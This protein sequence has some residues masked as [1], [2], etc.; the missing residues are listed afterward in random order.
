MNRSNSRSRGTSRRPT[1]RHLTRIGP[2]HIVHMLPDNSS[3]DR[4]SIVSPRKIRP[5]SRGTIRRAERSMSMP[6]SSQSRGP[7]PTLHRRRQSPTIPPAADPRPSAQSRSQPARLRSTSGLEDR[8]DVATTIT[9]GPRSGGA[10]PW[11]AKAATWLG[12]PCSGGLF[13]MPALTGSSRARCSRRNP[14]EAEQAFLRAVATSSPAR[15][16]AV[17]K[18]TETGELASWYACIHNETLVF[19]IH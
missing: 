3:A 9:L 6:P 15:C 18:V 17:Q 11:V 8:D 12:S 4:T 5:R 10:G 16:V 19:A 7:H 13:P 14:S 1:T 2:T